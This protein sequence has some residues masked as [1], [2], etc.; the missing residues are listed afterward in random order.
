MGT[1]SSSKVS[2]LQAALIIGCLVVCCL[3]TVLISMF[4][5]FHLELVLGNRT[6]IENLERKR[7]EETG[8]PSTDVSPVTHPQ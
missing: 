1:P 8:Q 6:T 7:Q 3:V 5:K 4:L 2:I